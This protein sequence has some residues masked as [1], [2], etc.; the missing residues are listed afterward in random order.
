MIF[1][2]GSNIF[3]SRTRLYGEEKE[4]VLGNVI[5]SLNGL[6]Q[7]VQSQKHEAITASYYL[8][9]SKADVNILEARNPHTNI[10][11]DAFILNETIPPQAHFVCLNTRFGKGKIDL[12]LARKDLDKYIE[13]K[14]KKKV[15][16]PIL[17]VYAFLLFAAAAY[18]RWEIYTI[19]TDVADIQN[20]IDSPEI[21]Q[22]LELLSLLM[23]ETARH[24]EVV[25]QIE[26][27]TSWLSALPVATSELLDFIIHN[28][29][30]PVTV[31]DFDFNE[32]SNVVRVTATAENAQFSTDYVNA[33]YNRGVAYN[34]HYQG[35]G[36]IGDLFR[37]T[38]DITLAVEGVN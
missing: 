20:Y 33:L 27:K 10:K 8:G 25:R 6:I 4:Q 1:V 22:R 2:D 13:K 18:L 9:I 34:V 21:S 5:E 12:L 35:Y 30:T 15:W 14:R 11:L 23:L 28:H 32:G 36:S 7:F 16:I 3:M 17:A 31:I 24:N 29:R 26:Y 38:I 19:E 37:F